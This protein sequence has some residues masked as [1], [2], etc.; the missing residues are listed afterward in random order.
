[1]SQPAHISAFQNS[2]LMNLKNEFNRLSGYFGNGME[3]MHEVG[4]GFGERLRDRA[5]CVAKGARRQLSRGAFED[6]EEMLESHLREHSTLY[7]V[8]G[9]AL[10]GLIVARIMSY[11]RPPL[12]REW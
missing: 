11:S 12:R 5:E 6:A 7:V 3:K 10:L 4:D 2:K 8:V 9:L 1:M